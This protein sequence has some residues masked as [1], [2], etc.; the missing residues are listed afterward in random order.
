MTTVQTFECSATQI[1]F[2]FTQ[3]NTWKSQVKKFL[4]SILY[5]SVSVYQPVHRP[6]IPYF[7]MID[8]LRE[9]TL[10]FLE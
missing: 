7:F 8:Y 1:V 5:V 4:L 9:I 2:D 10:I 6:F 3:F